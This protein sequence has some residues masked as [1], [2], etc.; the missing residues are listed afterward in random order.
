MKTGA[1][2]GELAVVVAR[3]RVCMCVRGV[4]GGRG[5]DGHVS[6]CSLL[7]VG[8]EYGARSR[9]GLGVDRERGDSCTRQIYA[10]R[11]GNAAMEY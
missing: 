7:C 1:A 9:Y 4:K 6:T 10:V 5:G 11:R 3:C 8:I 2:E